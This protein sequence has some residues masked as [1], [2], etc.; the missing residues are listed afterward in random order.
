MR[1]VVSVVAGAALVAA[2]AMPS[3]ASDMTMKGE[4]VDI[5]CATSKGDA[6]KGDAHAACAMACA[7]RGQPAGI[8]TAD[9]VYTITG[10]YAANNGAKLL[11][12]IA[13]RVIVTGQVDEKNGVKTIDVKS[14]KIVN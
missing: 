11:G 8:L 6:G 12:F 9:A 5:A 14:M 1:N 4:V 3:F 7:K 13:K 10:D 2:L